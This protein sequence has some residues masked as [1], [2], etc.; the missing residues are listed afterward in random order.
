MDNNSAPPKRKYDW[1]DS[2]TKID[3]VQAPPPRGWG[4][5]DQDQKAEDEAKQARRQ[6][7]V[8]GT[9]EIEYAE[10]PMQVSWIPEDVP[11]TK[12]NL[13]KHLSVTPEERVRIWS[14]EQRDPEWLRHR[15]GRLSGSKVGSAA[16][17]NKYETPDQL[18]NKWLYVPQKDNYA[19]RWGRE[20]EDEARESYRQIKLAQQRPHKSV[21]EFDR[22][23]RYLD[24]DFQQLDD[25][26]PVEPN[27][28]SDEPYTNE[29]EVK[30]LVVHP[31]IHWF[32]YSP[33]G[34]VFETDDKGLLEIKC[35]QR[36]PYPEIPWS[37][38]D[39]IQ[40]G[41][42]NFELRWCDFFAWT[43]AETKLERFAVNEDY[44][45]HDLYPKI[46]DFYMEKFLPAAIEAIE[47]Q[48]AF[49]PHSIT[50][51]KKLHL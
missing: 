9:V 32:G 40:F 47:K 50:Y 20:H 19:M 34:E 44:W 45:N 28:V 4:W 27:D 51:T 1:M 43:P 39:Q 24:Q 42:F 12:E 14:I 49:D 41:M 38:Y 5:T 15:L 31:T 22:P 3:V 8:A 2:L 10:P 36:G 37:Y 17:H 23:P 46:E 25:V 6:R 48:R 33:D 13:L 16:G 35:P 21:V 29:V 18:V 11:V 30:G 7:H 26:V